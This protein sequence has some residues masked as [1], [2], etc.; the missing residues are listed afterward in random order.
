VK[1]QGLAV[2]LNLGLSLV[3]VAGEKP[4]YPKLDDLIPRTVQ[5][6]IRATKRAR[7]RTQRARTVAVSY[8]PARVV[9][10][11]V[12]T[13]VRLQFGGTCSTFGLVA[14]A[15][16]LLKNQDISERHLWSTY[17]RPDAFAAVDAFRRNRI[18][19]EVDWP[20]SQ[21]LPYKGYQARARFQ[22][23]DAVYVG[24]NVR[25]VMDA[26]DAGRP[27]AI[28]TTVTQGLKACHTFINP[29]SSATLGGHFMAI[30][31]YRVDPTVEGGGYLKVKNSWGKNC[32]EGGFQYIPFAHCTSREDLMCSMWTLAVVKDWAKAS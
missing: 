15:E 20:Q 14:A 1:R 7:A 12:T 5:K 8:G 3:A 9:N 13:P 16:V 30:V 24:D 32:G 6:E 26:I 31:G 4:F 22:L 2:L 11:A 28:A 27:G 18:V 19:H 10:L 25:A 21:T 23:I 29:R 17:Q